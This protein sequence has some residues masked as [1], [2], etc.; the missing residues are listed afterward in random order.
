M[1]PPQAGAAHFSQ[2]SAAAPQGFAAHSQVRL[3]PYSLATQISSGLQSTVFGGLPQA[4]PGSSA[5]PQPAAVSRRA[6]MT[7]RSAR[8][9]MDPAPRKLAGSPRF[10]KPAARCRGGRARGSS[11]RLAEP[12]ATE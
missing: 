3:V 2:L 11:G 5:E 6:K 12:L 7:Q 9:S 10:S 1:K 4:N 8:R